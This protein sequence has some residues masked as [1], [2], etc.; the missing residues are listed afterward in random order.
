MANPYNSSMGLPATKNRYTI[1]EYLVLERAAEFRHEYD[2][3]EILAMSG[4]SPSQSFIIT[5]FLRV[6]GNT[7]IGKPCRIAE[8]NLRIAIARNAKY[9]YPDAS[10]ICGPLQFDLNDKLQHTVTNPRVIIEVLSPSTEAYDR[11]EKF[12]SY[13]EIESFEEYI[14]ISQD[15]AR[16]ES[17]LRQPDG[18]W[19]FLVCEGLESTAKIRC[20]NI[21]IPMKE[22][23]AGIEF[24][25]V[26]ENIIPPDS[27][28]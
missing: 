8:S 15:H 19:T 27:S 20:L 14:L 28:N 6:V 22:I 16:Y 17:I 2:N 21:E 12:N 1:D 13:R 24:P 9:V 4:G 25:V 3:G 5:N 11:G 10:I 23:F 18:A 7:L 26:V